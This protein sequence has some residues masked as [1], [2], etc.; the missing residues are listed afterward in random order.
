M[1]IRLI[2]FIMMISICS[3]CTILFYNYRSKYDA[4]YQITAN[5]NKIEIGQYIVQEAK[6]EAKPFYSVDFNPDYD[7][8]ILYG[9]DYHTLKYFLIQSDSSVTVKFDYFGYNGWRG[10]PPRK[11]FIEKIKSKLIDDFGAI[12][13]V[14][15]NLNNEK[16]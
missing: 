10:N 4:D 2:Y 14:V 12:E 3:S 15:T 16:K 7:S 5:S 9:P 6:N 1:K 13:T 8:I 11:A